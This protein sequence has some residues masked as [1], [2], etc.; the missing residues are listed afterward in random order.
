MLEPLGRIEG[1]TFVSLQRDNQET[2]A[3]P[4]LHVDDPIV[5]FGDLAAVIAHL[6]GALGKPTWVLLPNVGLDW[7][8]ERD[9]SESAWYPGVMRLFRQAPSE[10]DWSGTIERVAEAL[11]ELH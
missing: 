4:M 5:H 11:S 8:W 2:S 6:A 7:R 3:L 10:K 1:A 9:G